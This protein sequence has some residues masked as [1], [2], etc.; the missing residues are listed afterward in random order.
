MNAPAKIFKRGVVKGRLPGKE[1][2]R[3]EGR[4]KKRAKRIYKTHCASCDYIGGKKCLVHYCTEHNVNLE[5][6]I[7]LRI[8]SGRNCKI[9]G[10]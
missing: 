1:F 9:G 8:A 3:P 10:F 5:E 6:T 7:L 2:K 4:G